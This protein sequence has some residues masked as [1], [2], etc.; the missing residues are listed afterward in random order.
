[1]R[2]E[3]RNMGLGKKMVG[4]L[5]RSVKGNKLEMDPREVSEELA[6][7]LRSQ[8]RKSKNYTLQQHP[9]AH[10]EKFDVSPGL[11][12]VQSPGR[13]WVPGR[14]D[15]PRFRGPFDMTLTGAGGVVPLQKG[16]I[17]KGP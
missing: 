11:E 8:A 15:G 10:F 9:E 16:T 13:W 3:F 4:D 12:N 5:L 14:T 17:K 2:P 7:V 1:M 6:R